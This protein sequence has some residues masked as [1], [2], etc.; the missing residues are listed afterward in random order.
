MKCGRWVKHSKVD[1]GNG[2]LIRHGIAAAGANYL[3]LG[4]T[5]GKLGTN[6]LLPPDF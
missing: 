5:L 6:P 2:C 1:G 3:L 4:V